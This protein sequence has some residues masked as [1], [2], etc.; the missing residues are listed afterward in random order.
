MVLMLLLSTCRS[1]DVICLLDRLNRIPLHLLATKLESVGTI[2]PGP[3][4]TY[5]GAALRKR[6]SLMEWLM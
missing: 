5:S 1:E 2:E 6:A 4:S 3:G